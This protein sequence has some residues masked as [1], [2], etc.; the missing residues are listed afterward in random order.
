MTKMDFDLNL[1]FFFLK[2][3]F[4]AL[5]CRCMFPPFGKRFRRRYMADA[6]T[7]ARWDFIG[8]AGGKS[9]LVS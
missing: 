6:L 4:Y 3:L 8:R 9:A 2:S 7:S 1:H 5:W